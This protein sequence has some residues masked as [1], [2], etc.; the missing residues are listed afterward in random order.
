[1]LSTTR[2]WLRPARKMKRQ[3]VS[4]SQ[5]TLTF[6]LPDDFG[7]GWDYRKV[8]LYGAGH[9]WA[10]SYNRD[11]NE[12]FAHETL[13]RMPGVD[14]TSL[15][16]GTSCTVSFMV[17]NINEASEIQ[18]RLQAIVDAFPQ[19]ESRDITVRGSHFYDSEVTE[20][21][22]AGK[23]VIQMPFLAYLAKHVPLAASTHPALE[24]EDIPTVLAEL[25]ADK[26]TTETPRG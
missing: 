16:V 10:G 14:Q 7:S 24:G 20:H 19:R 21:D 25:E 4:L 22:A 2:N 17:N 9:A 18:L 3:K 15:H 1:V 12:N 5:L 11:E 8:M 13:H 26:P 6:S 23:E